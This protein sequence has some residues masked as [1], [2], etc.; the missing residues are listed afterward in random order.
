MKKQTAF[1]QDLVRLNDKIDVL[2]T[3]IKEAIQNNEIK[4]QLIPRS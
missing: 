3:L 1:T 4:R 2:L